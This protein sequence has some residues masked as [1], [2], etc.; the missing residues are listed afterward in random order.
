MSRGDIQLGQQDYCCQLDFFRKLKEAPRQTCQPNRIS[1][2]GEKMC[3]LFGFVSH[4]IKQ[5]VPAKK[6]S[7][8]AH[9]RV[10]MILSKHKKPP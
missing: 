5:R 1:I 8:D 9:N 4:K 10:G 6:V 3:S 7:V 2:P